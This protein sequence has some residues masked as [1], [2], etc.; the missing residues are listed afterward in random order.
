VCQDVPSG[1]A[2]QDR[3]DALRKLA[4]T[5]RAALKCEMYRAIVNDLIVAN[6]SLRLENREGKIFALRTYD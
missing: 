3:S 6:P 5:R 1:R 4:F 2:S